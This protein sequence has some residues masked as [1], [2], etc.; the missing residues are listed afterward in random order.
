MAFWNH[1]FKKEDGSKTLFSKIVGGVVSLVSKKKDSN[2]NAAP[3][4]DVQQAVLDN[5]DAD[6]SGGS[7]WSMLGISTSSDKPLI[8]FSQLIKLPSITAKVDEGQARSSVITIIA[9]VVGCYFLFS[10]KRKANNAK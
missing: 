3:N 7:I 2:N 4:N 9:I 6:H 8:D 10:R 1:L 5:P